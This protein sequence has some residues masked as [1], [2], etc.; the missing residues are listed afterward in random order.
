MRN[1]S[2]SVT[3]IFL[4]GGGLS[5][6]MNLIEQFAI[7]DGWKLLLALF[8]KETKLVSFKLKQIHRNI[9]SLTKINVLY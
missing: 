1:S 5:V 9:L 3:I 7:W 2:I 4:I 6:L 8:A